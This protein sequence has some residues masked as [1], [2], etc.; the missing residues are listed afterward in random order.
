MMKGQSCLGCQDLWIF[1]LVSTTVFKCYF[2][3]AS[4][5]VLTAIILHYL[6][7]VFFMISSSSELLEFIVHS[8]H[9]PLTISHS[10]LFIIATVWFWGVLRACSILFFA[11]VYSSKFSTLS[12]LLLTIACLPSP[13]LH[14]A[15]AAKLLQSCPTLCNP[16]DC[17]QPGSPVAGPGKIPEWVAI[18]SSRGFS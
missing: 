8:I 14:H 3:V 5:Q 13:F 16:M 9:F 10:F 15:A 4:T 6:S 17:S 11:V 7:Q 1:F 2:W 18:F 12:F